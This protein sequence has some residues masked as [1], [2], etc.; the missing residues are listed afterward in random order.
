[1]EIDY[2]AESSKLCALAALILEAN[3][4]TFSYIS[5][6]IKGEVLAEMLILK[7]SCLSLLLISKLFL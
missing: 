3:L 2:K 1:M 7:N 4:C 6:S 5:G